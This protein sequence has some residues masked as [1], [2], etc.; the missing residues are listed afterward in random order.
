M[1]SAPALIA[2]AVLALL[3]ITAVFAPLLAPYDPTTMDLDSLRQPPGK[4]HLLGTDSK[5]RDILSRMI[6][7]ARISLAVGIAASFLSL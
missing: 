6:Y 5:G 7:G 4:A 2:A 3:L 1:S